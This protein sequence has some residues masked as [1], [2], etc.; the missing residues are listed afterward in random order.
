MKKIRK[1]AR[2]FLETQKKENKRFYSIDLIDNALII[3]EYN[4]IWNKILI[5]GGYRKWRKEISNLIW[6]NEI[7]NSEI[8]LDTTLKK[9]LTGK[10]L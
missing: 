5:T 9:N 10:Q 4:L 3:N 6:K 7:L 2:E 1:E 8:Y